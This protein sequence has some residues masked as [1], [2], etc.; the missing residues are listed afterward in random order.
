MVVKRLTPVI[1][2]FAAI[3][4]FA[5]A[6]FFIFRGEF[7]AVFDGLMRNSGAVMRRPEAA[8]PAEVPPRA[9]VPAVKIMPA[10]WVEDFGK[11][12]TAGSSDLPP[13]W[14]VENKPGT[15]LASF[16]VRND[17]GTGDSFL[18]M[19]ADKASASVITKLDGVD[20]KKT[21]YLRWRWR[22]K[23]LP[24]GADGRVRSRDDQAIGIYVGSGSTLNNKSVS[25]RWD[26][27]TPIAAEGNASYGFG[28]IKVK[29][30]TLRNKEDAAAGEWIEEER[31][32]AEDFKRAWGYYPDDIY[33]SVSCN[34]QY[35]GSQAVADLDW[36]GFDAQ[37]AGNS[38]ISTEHK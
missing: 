8:R 12:E 2:F 1:L 23:V 32:V 36:I 19:E 30:H 7:K 34:S 31:N 3:G 11:S 6:L 38:N 10:G 4:M 29:W 27:Q 25:Y 26:T 20:I 18:R 22:V 35:T 16:S 24:E 15:A 17:P 5:A 9:T 14:V 37:P 21:P 33:L 13:G 28:V